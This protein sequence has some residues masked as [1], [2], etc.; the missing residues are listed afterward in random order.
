MTVARLRHRDRLAAPWK[1]G[2]GLTHEIAAWPAGA[3]LTDF[4]WRLSLATVAEAGPFSAFPGVDRVLTVVDGRLNLAM[5]GASAHLLTTHSEPF[6]FSGE[7]SVQA[8]APDGPATDVNVMTRRDRVAATVERRTGP[9]EINLAVAR[10]VA[11]VACSPGA[12]VL[13]GQ[14]ERLDRFDALVIER[15]PEPHRLILPA[16]THIIL[17]YLTIL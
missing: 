12:I 13:D 3:A 15:G 5:D 6:T 4:G 17:A 10:W 14:S 16:E 11:I 1:N 7:A 9:G 2:G 8:A